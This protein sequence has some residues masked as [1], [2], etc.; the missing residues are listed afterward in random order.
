MGRCLQ[1]FCIGSRKRGNTRRI[2]N[3]QQQK[4]REGT[5]KEGFD[6]SYGSGIGLMAGIEK[7]GSKIVREKY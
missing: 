6:R 3:E 4:T 2:R 5:F 7:K 1:V